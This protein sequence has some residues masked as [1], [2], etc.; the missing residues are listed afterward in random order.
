MRSILWYTRIGSFMRA[1]DNPW[2]A[3]SPPRDLDLPRLD[4]PA[5]ARAVHGDL[6]AVAP[7]REARQV[8]RQRPAGHGAAKLG[9]LLPLEP[10]RSAP[11]RDVQRLRGAAQPPR[12]DRQYGDYGGRGFGRVEPSD[13]PE[14]PDTRAPPHDR[15][16]PHVGE[17]RR[18]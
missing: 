18:E 15:R 10:H 7:R 16:A 2:P 13:L 9:Q 1:H 5:P 12:A 14:Q 17:H 11:A 6:D 8:D 4:R 3:F